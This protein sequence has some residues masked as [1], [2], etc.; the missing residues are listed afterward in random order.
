M[1]YFVIE[2]VTKKAT[3]FNGIDAVLAAY[4][5]LA[6]KQDCYIGGASSLSTLQVISDIMDIDSKAGPSLVCITQ[7]YK[8]KLTSHNTSNS[9]GDDTIVCTASIA[10]DC[11][12]K[13]IIKVAKTTTSYSLRYKSYATATFTLESKTVAAT[14]GGT[15]GT[16]L[17]IATGNFLDGTVYVGD[18]VYNA[19][20]GSYATIVSIDSAT[21]LT[22]TEL[23]G[24]SDNTYTSTDSIKIN[25]LPAT[26]DNTWSVYTPC[27]D[28][29]YR[30]LYCADNVIHSSE[31]LLNDVMPLNTTQ[32][33]YCIVCDASAGTY[34]RY[35]YTTAAKKKITLT[36]TSGVCDAS[37]N[38]TTLID[39]AGGFVDADIKVGDIIYN[40]TDGS[41]AAVVSVDSATQLTTGALSGGTANVWAENDEYTTQ[42]T[43]V[44]LTPNDF[45]LLPTWKSTP[46]GLT[47]FKLN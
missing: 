26:V 40:V 41:S 34:K 37:G 25:V 36:T 44:A 11:P 13:G 47:I 27:V 46:T 43:S 14:T 35:R 28:N 17:K 5:Q 2:T 19:T 32:S 4:P 3:E 12:N 23:A 8:D 24:G 30:G 1:K 16:V 38:A 6:V 39:A 22:T 33:S 31:I 21:Q 42:V 10:T 18:I 9:A 45:V 15:G 29:V 7:D 20:D